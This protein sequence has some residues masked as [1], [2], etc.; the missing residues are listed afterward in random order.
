MKPVAEAAA[1]LG[2]E[3]LNCSADDW[4]RS[5]LVAKFAR[6]AEIAE[7]A[8]L[9]VDLECMAFRG[10]DSPEKC[11]EVIDASG[12][13]NAGLKPGDMIRKVDGQTMPSRVEVLES[14]SQRLEGE[15]VQLTILRN[16]RV[17]DFQVTLGAYNPN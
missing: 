14:I 4:E 5:A 16:G 10:I 11:H 13:A 6:L 17:Q 12:A 15:R 9:G 3:R 1:E 7:D 2:A 8:G